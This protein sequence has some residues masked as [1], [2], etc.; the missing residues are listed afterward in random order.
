MG[1]QTP[2]R[3]FDLKSLR[4]G[5][6]SIVPGSSELT[7][8]PE[9]IS[10]EYTQNVKKCGANVAVSKDRMESSSQGLM[11]SDSALED[12]FDD[13]NTH[14]TQLQLQSMVD[15]AKESLIV[16]LKHT[17]DVLNQVQT[18]FQGLYFKVCQLDHE[19]GTTNAKFEKAITKATHTNEDTKIAADELRIQ[20][21]D[22]K[23]TLH[24]LSEDVKEYRAHH[25][26]FETLQSDRNASFLR[27]ADTA[28]K[29]FKDD[30]QQ[31]QAIGT[32]LDGAEEAQRE[33]RDMMTTTNTKLD[34]M[35]KL[36]MD[37]TKGVTDVHHRIADTKVVMQQRIKK[38]HVEN[39]ELRMKFESMQEKLDAFSPSE[40][41][42][43]IQNREDIDRLQRKFKETEENVENLLLGFGEA[44]QTGDGTNA[45]T[46]CDSNCDCNNELAEHL[47]QIHD[48]QNILKEMVR[49]R[50]PR[51]EE[52]LKEQDHRYAQWYSNLEAK[53]MLMRDE[54]DAS[55]C[56]LI[57]RVDRMENDLKRCFERMDI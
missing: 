8:K 10:K 31:R 33:L 52:S 7:S 27:F 15:E 20:V 25:E 21:E 42:Y 45:G 37:F 48:Q 9:S 44:V 1:H 11:V 54:L 36:Q 12:D 22:M 43:A 14:S 49:D 30:L 39:G 50:F 23:I 51:L 57:A 56:R 3:S 41:S 47:N 2:V 17:E 18:G 38:V 4:V 19:S 5:P 16:R 26:H 6:F 34:G 28:D 13:C 29:I 55:E 35:H 24:K 40:I 53:R 32:R 46:I